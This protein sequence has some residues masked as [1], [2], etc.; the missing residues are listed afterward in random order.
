MASITSP[1]MKIAKG[2]VFSK[3]ALTFNVKI[4]TKEFKWLVTTKADEVQAIITLYAK[5]SQE[6]GKDEVLY[7]YHYDL[8]QLEEIKGAKAAATKSL[9][10]TIGFKIPTKK[11]DEDKASDPVPKKTKMAKVA[12]IRPAKKVAPKRPTTR[13]VMNANTMR[14]EMDEIYAVVYLSVKKGKEE[15][16]EAFTPVMASNTVMQRF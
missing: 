9:P 11:L 1:K 15:A 2:P 16:W 13:P 12:A 8:D 3:V 6:G 7:T 5:D 10:V 4:D 14:K